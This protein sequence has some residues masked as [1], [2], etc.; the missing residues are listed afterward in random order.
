MSEDA[1]KLLIFKPN[2][3]LAFNPEPVQ[4]EFAED[5]DGNGPGLGET[6]ST[7]ENS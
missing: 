5:W 2:I 4:V 6:R 7:Q 3:D 1:F